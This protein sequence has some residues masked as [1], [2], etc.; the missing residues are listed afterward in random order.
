[1]RFGAL[2][3]AQHGRHAPEPDDVHREVRERVAHI[4]PM[5]SFDHDPY[6]VLVDGRLFW[7]VDAYTTTSAY[8]YSRPAAGVNY[9]RNA[10][11]AVVDAYNGTTRSTWWI[12]RIR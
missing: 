4:A 5:L 7:I 10:V 1:M 3:G 2:S 11:K 6:L 12:P 9:I 8:P